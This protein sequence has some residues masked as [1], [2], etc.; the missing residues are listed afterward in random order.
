[1][2]NIKKNAFTMYLARICCTAVLV[3]VLFCTWY[4][5]TALSCSPA[6]FAEASRSTVSWT[7][8]GHTCP[9]FSALGYIHSLLCMPCYA[10][11]AMHALLCVPCYARLVWFW[12]FYRAEREGSFSIPTVRSLVSYLRT[13]LL[14]H[15]LLPY[16][17]YTYYRC[18]Q[19]E[20]QKMFLKVWIHIILSI[21]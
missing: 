11:L 16:I 13:N 10:C 18:T 1:M 14:T 20:D 19:R 7:C 21:I 9:P 6:Q 8:L 12:S 15:T 2:R 5:S 17:S 4:S 3:P